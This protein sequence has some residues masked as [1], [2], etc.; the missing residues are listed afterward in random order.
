MPLKLTSN[1]SNLNIL[2]VIMSVSIYKNVN[3]SVA[4]TSFI[5]WLVAI[6]TLNYGI[7]YRLFYLYF[8]IKIMNKY[9]Y[10]YIISQKTKNSF[11]L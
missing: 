3:N 5:S 4:S 7:N 11:I 9:F 2:S 10:N 1:S 6:Y 8:I